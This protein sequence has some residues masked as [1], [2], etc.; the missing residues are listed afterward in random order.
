MRELN[1]VLMIAYRDVMKLLGDKQRLVFG[2]IFPVFFIGVLGGTMQANL[3]QA[4]GYD[5]RPFI[6]TGIFA[7]SLFQSTAQG[8]ISLI[9][10]RESDFSQEMFVAP[11]SRYS[12]IFGKILGESGVAFVQ[13]VPILVLGLLVG[14]SLSL[15]QVLGL[16]VVGAIVCLFGGAFGVLTL[17]NLKDQ[18][19]VSQ[20]VP[21][22]M[23]PQLFLS[24]AFVPVKQLPL[25]L[26]VLSRISP[27]RYAVDLT[28]G[29][30]YLGTPDYA[31]VVMD[32]TALDLF[33]IA[34]LF[35]IFLA[36]GTA[37]FVRNERNR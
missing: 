28:R 29:T 10:D 7:Q 34:G 36:A 11:I 33:V 31:K 17:S 19:S 20:I 5:F 15:V 6:F 8:I 1:A 30:F 3:G 22:I 12:I 2:L 37:M 4:A 18:R 13:G 26:E 24:G 32:P 23:L 35:V 9:A 21:F 16:I 27:M 14:V 25:P